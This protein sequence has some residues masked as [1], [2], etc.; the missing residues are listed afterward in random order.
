MKIIDEALLAEAAAKAS[1]EPKEEKGDANG[2]ALNEGLKAIG[3]GLKAI[4]APKRIRKTADGYLS[5]ASD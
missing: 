2:A 4:G 5:E 3:E 1:E